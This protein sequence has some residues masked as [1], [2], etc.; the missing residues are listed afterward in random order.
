LKQYFNRM[1]EVGVCHH[2]GLVH[3]DV[4]RE[5]EKVARMLKMPCVRLTD[6]N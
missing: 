6:G 3:G 4:S 1:K 5:L 2:F